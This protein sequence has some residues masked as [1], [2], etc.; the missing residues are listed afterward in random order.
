[1][2]L[3]LS[4]G[5]A[6]QPY[7]LLYSE[8]SLMAEYPLPWVY[9]DLIRDH[10]KIQG[11]ATGQACNSNWLGLLALGDSSSKAAVSDALRPKAQDGSSIG[12]PVGIL[13]DVKVDRQF[14]TYLG[15]Y[16]R[17]C[18]MVSGIWAIPKSE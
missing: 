8:I 7:G 11:Y 5:C 10:Y 4:S 9:S 18:T 14:H 13:Y 16:S 17:F 12:E 1:M 6:L 15:L 2:I 3:I